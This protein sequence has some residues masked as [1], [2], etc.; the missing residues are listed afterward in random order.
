MNKNYILSVNLGH[1]LKQQW[2]LYC[3]NHGVTPSAAIRQVVRKL[4]SKDQPQVRHFDVQSEQPD[5][6]RRRVELRLTE[7]EYTAIGLLARA[8]ESSPNT[9]I[10]NLIRA[11]LTR[12]A[13]LGMIEL[14]ALGK[15][16]SELLAIG[17]NINQ[18]ARWMNANNGS[19]PPEQARIDA[20]YKLIVEHTKSVSE[21]MRANIDRWKIN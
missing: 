6:L 12:S 7:S 8:S 17:R 13:Q 21:V 15:S 11:N 9:W 3:A 1:D 5:L 19:A 16:N 18:I 14:H 2:C 20:I 10:V 4:I